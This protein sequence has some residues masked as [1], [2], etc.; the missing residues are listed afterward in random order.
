M[1]IKT[2][3]GG[4]DNNLSYVISCDKTNKCAIIDTSISLNP[5]IEYIYESDL[6]LDKILI[7]HTHHDHIY[8]LDD[9][10]YEFPNAVIC[11][12]AINKKN[13]LCKKLDDNQL[14]SIGEE[15]IISLPL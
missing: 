6:I 9:Y 10:L 5:L 1:K 8:F 2:F 12:H 4:Y 11:S 7:T 13:Y 3:Q 15:I 14:V